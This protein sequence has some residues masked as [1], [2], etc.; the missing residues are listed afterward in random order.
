VGQIK[1]REYPSTN[2]EYRVEVL[3]GGIPSTLACQKSTLAAIEQRPRFRTRASCAKPKIDLGL[4]TSSILA[5]FATADV[6]ITIVVPMKWDRLTAANA[7]VQGANA[8]RG[9]RRD[10]VGHAYINV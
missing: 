7:R 4:P 5:F 8:D 3:A 1:Q 2:T 6:A 9:R 10:N